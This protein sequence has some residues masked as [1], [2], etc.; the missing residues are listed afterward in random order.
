MIQMQ[1]QGLALDPTTNMP[2]VILKG[3]ND[4]IL[5]I[6]IGS[7]E[8]NA[9]AMKLENVNAPRP[10]THDLITNLI[11]GMNGKVEYIHI[12]DLKEGTYYAEI[13][14]NLDGKNISIDSRPSDAINVALRCDAPIYVSDEVLKATQAK[15]EDVD[16][17]EV[18]EWLES[19]KP[20][21]FEKEES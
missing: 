17:D 10:M 5:S 19:L 20:E 11:E 2:V 16:I 15:M 1:V 6:W 12:N 13:V 9:I 8:A 4:E 3:E 14:I 7:F 21:D 18:K